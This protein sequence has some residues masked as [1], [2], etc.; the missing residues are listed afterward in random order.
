MDSS[1]DPVPDS[2]I[3]LQHQF[4][5]FRS[6][7]TGR[8]KLPEA[9]WQAAVE[10]AKQYGVNVVSK[11]AR[12]DYTALKKRLGTVPK[13]QEPA[14]TGFVELMSALGDRDDQYVIE[15]ESSPKPRMR[16]QWR[17]SGP[18]DWSALLRAWWE[19]VG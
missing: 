14:Q 3:Q 18:P 8:P 19:V 4:E 7:H 2:I 10:Q 15:F 1:H 5:E 6:A 13:P 12:L 17:G 11:R 9:L 16:V